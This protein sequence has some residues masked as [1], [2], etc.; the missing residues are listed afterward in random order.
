[1]RNRKFPFA[2]YFE[3]PLFLIV[4]C[5]ATILMTVGCKSAPTS[6]IVDLQKAKNLAEVADAVYYVKNGKHLTDQL[7]TK[8]YKFDINEKGQIILT[9]KIDDSPTSLSINISDLLLNQNK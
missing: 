3:A 4:F 7:D 8:D 5:L 9:P 2:S 1:M 6:G